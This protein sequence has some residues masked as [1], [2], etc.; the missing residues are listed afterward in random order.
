MAASD[1]GIGEALL[2]TLET[3]ERPVAYFSNHLNRAKKN[4]V[5]GE[6]KMQ[7]IVRSVKHFSQYLYPCP[8]KIR[9]DHRLLTWILTTERPASR[10][11]HWLVTLSGFEFTIEYKPGKVNLSDVVESRGQKDFSMNEHQWKEHLFHEEQAPATPIHTQS[12]LTG[13]ILSLRGKPQRTKVS[14]S[15]KRVDSS[16]PSVICLRPLKEPCNH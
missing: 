13:I 11:A 5:A 6:K 14:K 7:A 2:Q 16:S 10:I 9:T 8:F 12:F 4:Y 3:I 15:P 1:F